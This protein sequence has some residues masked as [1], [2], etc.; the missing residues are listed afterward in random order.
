MHMERILDMFLR[1]LEH[2]IGSGV[3]D[4]G[5]SGELASQLLWLL[6][7]DLYVHYTPDYS[8]VVQAADENPWKSELADC[9][10]ISVLDYF[11]FVFGPHFWDIAGKE[12]GDAFKD[13]FV[14]FSDW[15]AMDE[16]ISVSK[17]PDDQLNTGEWTLRHW[18][19]TS[20]VQC[21]HNQPLVDKMIPIYFKDYPGD[22]DLS[23]VSQIFVS[24]NAQ[25]SSNRGD[26]DN[27]IHDHDTI[28]CHSSLPWV[29]ISV[30]L[31]LQESVVDVKF[32]DDQPG[33]PC[34]RIYAAAINDK[35]FPFL[36][37]SKRLHSRI[38]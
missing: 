18:H 27:I 9:Q 31:G 22:T 17:N 10:M 36:E 21:S 30:D 15:V 34:L 8:T 5:K 2:K 19:R 37:E 11:R 20:A 33:G 4:V 28:Q 3:I 35:T 12:A 29:A 26:P 6:A 25:R 1:T 23:R 24:D 32:A 7:K 38:S 13:A 16:N 14:N